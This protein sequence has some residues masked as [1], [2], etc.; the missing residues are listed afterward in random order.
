ML[1]IFICVYVVWLFFFFK[2]VDPYFPLNKRIRHK[3]RSADVSNELMKQQET[4]CYIFIKKIIQKYCHCSCVFIQ[5]ITVDGS[6]WHFIST[7][8][9]VCLF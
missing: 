7:V 4:G 5:D 1:F 3:F 9:F 2:P 8:C 6:L